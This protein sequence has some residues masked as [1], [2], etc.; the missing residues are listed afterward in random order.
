MSMGTGGAKNSKGY[1]EGLKHALQKST[2]EGELGLWEVF[3][4]TERGGAGG[5]YFPVIP[6]RPEWRGGMALERRYGCWLQVTCSNR[7]SWAD[8]AQFEVQVMED[9]HLSEK[10]KFSRSHDNLETFLEGLLATCNY[11]REL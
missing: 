7:N 9:L 11:M 5:D 6:P 1:K 3:P 10:R 8:N 4:W 2:R